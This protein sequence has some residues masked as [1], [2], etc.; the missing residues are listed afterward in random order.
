MTKSRILLP[1]FC[2][3]VFG[4]VVVW[5]TAGQ[6]A[7]QAVIQAQTSGG[8]IVGIEPQNSG[9]SFVGLPELQALPAGT[10]QQSNTL[11]ERIF[12]APY[13]GDLGSQL[14]ERTGSDV[15]AGIQG[16]EVS[17]PLPELVGLSPSGERV[18]TAGNTR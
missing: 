5:L 10:G 11:P 18:T 14:P 15:A 2:L 12:N 8:E 16:A 13:P 4:L 3:V 9:G 6:E 17:G 1:F 7:S